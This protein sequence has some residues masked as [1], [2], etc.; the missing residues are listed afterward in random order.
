LA[1]ALVS[2]VQ[3]ADITNWAIVHYRN[4]SGSMMVPATGSVVFTRNAT[5]P[6]PPSDFL[7][8]VT[9]TAVVLSWTP[10]VPGVNA[11]SG[12]NVYRATYSG[13]A[14][15]AATLLAGVPGATASRYSDSAVETG[16]NYCYVV[17]AVDDLSIE[18]ASSSERCVQFHSISVPP[19]ASL[20][21]S[22]YDS[23]GRKIRTITQGYSGEAV[24]S[25]SIE[26]G[27]SVRLKPGENVRILLSEGTVI[28][29]DGRDEK[30]AP[31]DNGVYAIQLVVEIPDPSGT[32]VVRKY[33]STEL[34]LAWAYEKL[35]VSSVLV[36]NP[37]RDAVWLKLSLGAPGADV[38]IRVYSVSGE[39]VYKQKTT[40]YE[41]PYRWDL[42][43]R[44]GSKLAQGLYVVVIEARDRVTGNYDRR[45]LKLAVGD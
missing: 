25:I 44:S 22:V 18:S 41:S 13:S 30:G 10:S 21:L 27:G 26:G 43:N 32:G 2:T 29:W 42:R 14:P 8:S 5:Q 17:R 7:A 40:G 38:E 19:A 37:A 12:Y 20:I 33:V 24:T 3:G 6:S 15:S 31:V 39:L 36:P 35:I 45:T 23:S 11:L 1:C 4:E 28:T 34:T 9:D 16:G